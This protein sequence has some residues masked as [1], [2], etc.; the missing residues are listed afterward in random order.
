LIFLRIRTPKEKILIQKLKYHKERVLSHYFKMKVNQWIPLLK[1]M[2][3]DYITNVPSHKASEMFRDYSSIESLQNCLSKKLSKQIQVLLEKHSPV[4]QSGL[5]LQE[6]YYNAGI[7]FKIKKEWENNL[8]GNI[9]ILDDVFT[10]GATINEVSRILKLN[11]AS[12]VWCLVSLKGDDR[13]A[14]KQA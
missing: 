5:G 9:L 12:K 8:K 1:T 2:K 14:T 3:F 6:R 7:S 13:D 10:T 4:F 11:G